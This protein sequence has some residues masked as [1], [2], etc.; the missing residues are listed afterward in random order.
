MHEDESCSDLSQ[1]F[2]SRALAEG[3]EAKKSL[4]PPLCC[5]FRGPPLIGKKWADDIILACQSK[6]KTQTMQSCRLEN[7][8]GDIHHANTCQGYY[9][10]ILKIII[11]NHWNLKTNYKIEAFVN[12]PQ[13]IFTSDFF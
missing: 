3:I 4:R 12:L 1:K 6:D 8:F 13:C 2:T 9:V 7:I 10:P 5:W 11:S